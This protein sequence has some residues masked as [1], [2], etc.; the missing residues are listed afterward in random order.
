M[1]NKQNAIEW[2]RNRFET[3][4]HQNKLDYDD[5]NRGTTKKKTVACNNNCI[6]N[7]NNN[8]R[9]KDLLLHQLHAE[10]DSLLVKINQFQEQKDIEKQKTLC[11][12]I[13]QC[14]FAFFFCHEQCFQVISLSPKYLAT[15]TD[16]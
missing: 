13:E 9:N 12:Y 7:N 14:K 2:E 8:I 1:A 3:Q 11:K 6:I 10:Q 4:E 15:T 5:Y 16:S